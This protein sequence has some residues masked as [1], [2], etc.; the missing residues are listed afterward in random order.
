M[1]TRLRYL[2]VIL[3][4]ASF[5]APLRGGDADWTLGKVMMLL[6]RV[7]HLES[8]FVEK[9]RSGFL[10]EDLVL[11]GTIRFT[12][13]DTLEKHVL[14]P[15]DELILIDRNQI[16]IERDEGDS[17]QRFVR[18]IPPVVRTII[19]SVRATL[20]G[21]QSRL[22]R[23]YETAVTGREQS[24]S[25]QLLPKDP[26]LKQYLRAITIDGVGE[27]IMRIVTEEV[28]GDSS[29]IEITYKNIVAS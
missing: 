1:I 12:A 7:Q 25:L 11:S 5:A 6:A 27:K 14:S 17:V 2:T 24:W 9:K 4:L 16:T 28:D 26:E 18:V 23:H 19:D 3:V 22:E 15:F 29:V 8:T 13:P 10:K 21:D 20:A